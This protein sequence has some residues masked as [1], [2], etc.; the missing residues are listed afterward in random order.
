MLWHGP[1]PILGEG[2]QI[3]I[4]PANHKAS[5]SM[6]PE[7]TNTW[8]CPQCGA[9]NPKIAKTCQRCGLGFEGRPP[10][11]KTRKPWQTLSFW[12][13]MSLLG[14]ILLVVFV[15]FAVRT[16]FFSRT[17]SALQTVRPDRKQASERSTL[18]QVQSDMRS[19]ARAID[20]YRLDTNQ[21]PAA[22]SGNKGINAFLPSGD[23]GYEILTFRTRTLDALIM[24]LTTPLAY[25]AS[26]P[27]DPF[28]ETPGTSYAYYSHLDNGCILFSAGPDQDYDI[29]PAKDYDALANNPLPQLLMKTYDPTNG[30]TSDGDIWRICRWPPEMS[31]EPLPSPR[32]P[33]PVQTPSVDPNPF[34]RTQTDMRLLSKA[35]EMYMVD[36]TL[37]PAAAEADE[38]INAFL[39]RDDPGY[40]IL[41]FRARRLRLDAWV[42]T[43]TTPVAYM[44]SYPFDPFAKTPGT[45]YAYYNH[46]DK[47][48]IVFSAGPDGDYDIDPERDYD[49][50]ATNPLPQ[51]LWKTY[52]STNG[53]TSGGDIWRIKM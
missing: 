20:S 22:T 48:Y 25:M 1:S 36:M 10:L 12:V 29:D 35:I 9:E 49:A 15:P 19:L 43:L 8:K 23:P 17:P 31:S 14:L 5:N 37:Y 42:M 39:T 45:S 44:V 4:Q 7:K 13:L 21:Y 24:T 51:L 52:D 3:T 50:L 34:N 47:G 6:P 28:A 27:F 53:A 26:Y 33:V 18:N 32:T 11:R 41:T 46:L 30:A 16:P 38:G 2:K 40:N